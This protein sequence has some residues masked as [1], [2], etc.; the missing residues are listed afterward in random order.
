MKRIAQYSAIAFCFV[1]LFLG[2]S[3]FQPQHSC[4]AGSANLTPAEEKVDHLMA[5]L[6]DEQVRQMLIAELKKDSDLAEP[7]FDNMKG[8]A[9]ILSRSLGGLSSGHDANQD[10]LK[11][12][13][14]KIPQLLPD[15]YKVFIKL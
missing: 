3:L 10:E 8:P 5:G 4:A 1:T 14:S 9:S 7:G 15:L 13:F 6:S 11:G 2:T 12:L